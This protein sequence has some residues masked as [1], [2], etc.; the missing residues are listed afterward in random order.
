LQ[1]DLNDLQQFALLVSKGEEFRNDLD[2]EW[3]QF[4]YMAIAAHPEETNNIVKALDSAREQ[5]EAELDPVAIP[6]WARRITD[7]KVPEY[8]SPSAYAD[9]VIASLKEFGVYVKDI[10]D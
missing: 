1:G 2:A 8:E 3:R 7:D 4:K 5:A 6:E 9:E 10:P